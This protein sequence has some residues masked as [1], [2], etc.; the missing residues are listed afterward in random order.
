LFSWGSYFLAIVFSDGEVP[1]LFVDSPDASTVY[2]AP[3]LPFFLPSPMWPTPFAFGNFTFFSLRGRIAA[4]SPPEFH[5]YVCCV[6][7]FLLGLVDVF[8]YT[9]VP[10]HNLSLVFQFFFPFTP[11]VKRI[12]SFIAWWPNGRL[13][14]FFSG[15]FRFLSGLFFAAHHF[16]RGSFSEIAL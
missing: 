3:F 10:V 7:V 8:H 6:A 13:P 11:L 5:V 16:W 15:P 2:I 4:F 12:F 9:M 1:Y 14:A